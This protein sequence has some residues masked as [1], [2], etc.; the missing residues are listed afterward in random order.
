[1]LSKH[2]GRIAPLM[3]EN[4]FVERC[5]FLYSEIKRQQLDDELGSIRP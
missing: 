3:S 5:Y 2:K 4:S 1:M